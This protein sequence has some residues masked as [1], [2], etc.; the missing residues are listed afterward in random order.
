MLGHNVVDNF[1][2]IIGSSPGQD[3][4]HS[5]GSLIKSGRDKASTLLDG[6]GGSSWLDSV[7]SSFGDW[8]D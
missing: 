1:N 4:G 7:D 3:G 8:F 6:D 2:S 5:F